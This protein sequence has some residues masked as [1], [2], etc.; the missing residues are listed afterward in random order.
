M[1][2]KYRV[3]KI[4]SKSEKEINYGLMCEEDVRLVT[5]G[6]KQDDAIPSMYNRRGSRWFFVVD[7]IAGK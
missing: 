3:V 7:E 6:Y 2:K 5:R 1:E 4:D